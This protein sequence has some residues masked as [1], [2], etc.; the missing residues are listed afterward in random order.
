MYKIY[1]NRLDS[2]KC[3]MKRQKD[4]SVHCNGV[5]IMIMHILYWNYTD[6]V[7]SECL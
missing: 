5:N 1:N 7:K 3:D 6:K 2:V 4:T